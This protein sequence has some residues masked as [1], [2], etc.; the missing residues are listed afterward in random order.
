MGRTVAAA[1]TRRGVG[2]HSGRPCAARVAPAPPGH[3]LRL[4]GAPLGQLAVLSTRRATS[5]ATPTGPVATVEHLLA[6]LVGQGV[7]DAEVTVEGGEAPIL[8]GSAAPWAQALILVEHGGGAPWRPPRSVSVADGERWIRVSPAPALRLTVVAHH[9]PAPPWRCEV[10]LEDF[11]RDVAPA[12]TYVFLRDVAALRAAGLAQGGA[13]DNALVLTD[14]GAPVQGALRLPD[15]PARHKALDLL[16]DLAL[17]GRPLAAHV[18][19]HRPGHA[20]NQR[21]VAALRALA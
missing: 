4:N 12:R 21:L 8:D 10:G 3:G 6:A 17:L 13:L 14:A 11:A 15:E 16:G 1:V 7:T 9:P 5:V 19:A 2:L 20:L 18:E